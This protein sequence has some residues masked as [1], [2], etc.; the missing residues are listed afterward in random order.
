MRANETRP[1]ARAV[2]AGM[3]RS[4]DFCTRHGAATLSMVG[5]TA[6]QHRLPRCK[7][8]GIPQR[9]RA[10]NRRVSDASTEARKVVKLS[11]LQKYGEARLPRYTSYPPSPEFTPSVDVDTY[12]NWLSHLPRGAPASLYLHIPFCRSMCWYCGCHTTVT[13]KDQPIVEYLDLQRQRDQ[14]G[15]PRRRR[16]PFMSTGCTSAAVPPPSLRQRIS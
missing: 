14:I 10:G 12:A 11:V 6:P 4:F 3:A 7:T 1:T 13:A 5:A 2:A 8:F 15:S 9:S 16:S